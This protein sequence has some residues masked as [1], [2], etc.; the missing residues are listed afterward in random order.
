MISI[1]EALFSVSFVIAI[2]LLN[3]F[4]IVPSVTHQETVPKVPG[5]LPNLHTTKRKRKKRAKDQSEPQLTTTGTS[6]D[7]KNVSNSHAR[8]NSDEEDAL[9]P[10]VSDDSAFSVDAPVSNYDGEYTGTE[11]PNSSR[12]DTVANALHIESRPARDI[13]S[14]LVGRKSSPEN[15]EQSHGGGLRVLKIVG[16][17]ASKSTK[18]PTKSLAES[19]ELT[20]KQ[21]QNRKKYEAK[22][23]AKA[24]QQED[25]ERRLREFKQQRAREAVL[26]QQRLDAQKVRITASTHKY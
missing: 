12:S 24:V 9:A 14:D 4:R 10:E 2:I 7:E 3:R 17:N 21:R 16:S 15:P 22:K 1:I 26:E 8:L 25:Q 6:K 18:K 5:A 13:E 11:L 20:K 19:T 23:E